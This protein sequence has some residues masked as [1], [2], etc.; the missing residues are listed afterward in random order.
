MSILSR[1][2][3]LSLLLVVALAS[4]SSARSPWGR[5]GSDH[6]AG[7]LLRE[8]ADELGLD[9]QT[10]EA[11]REV[12]RSSREASEELRGELRGLHR[13]MKEMLSSEDPDEDAVMA[14]A[15]RIGGVETSV[16][17]QRLAAMLE[18]RSVLTPEQR[19]QLVE[20]RK[21]ERG[22][23]MEPLAEACREDVERL[24]SEVDSRFE[25]RRCMREHRDEVSD[26]CREAFEDLRGDRPHK[27][28]GGRGY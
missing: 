11:I 15:D 23:H 22:R 3:S 10:R 18:I 28:W 19:A 2:L 14:L 4:A 17:K 27:H 13:Q 26:A 24:C 25:R 5:G 8:H 16:H 7:S 1:S 9:E 21:E 6:G 12:I 20:L